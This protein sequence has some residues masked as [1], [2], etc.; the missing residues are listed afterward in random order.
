MLP[1][2]QELIM[3][4]FFFFCALREAAVPDLNP[5]QEGILYSIFI[6]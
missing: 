2:K 6:G 5:V 4:A 3:K 1:Q